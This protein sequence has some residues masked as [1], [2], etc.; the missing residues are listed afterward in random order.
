[1]RLEELYQLTVADCAGGWFDVRKAK[2][3]AG[4][5]KVPAHSALVAIVVRRCAGKA[6][7]DYLMGEPARQERRGHLL[8]A[9]FTRYRQA[10]GVH[11]PNGR[12]SRV[13]FHSWRRWF[14]TECRNAGHDTHVVDVLTG[15]AARGLTDGAYHAGPTEALLRAAVEAVRLPVAVDG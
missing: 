10:I 8:S 5:R 4:V 7:A 2:S 14:T 6:P 9:R 11:D 1:M 3:P 13:D 15:H 12:Q